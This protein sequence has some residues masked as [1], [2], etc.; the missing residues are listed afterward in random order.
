ME[1]V[2]VHGGRIAEFTE[3]TVSL[4]N[5]PFY[6]KSGLKIRNKRALISEVPVMGEKKVAA[7][8]TERRK[9]EGRNINK[10]ILPE[11]K[12]ID[13]RIRGN[14]RI[15]GIGRAASSLVGI[16]G[17]VESAFSSIDEWMPGERAV[18]VWSGV[19]LG[20]RISGISPKNAV[21]IPQNVSF[22]EA[23]FAVHGARAVKI[24]RSAD[25]KLGNHIAVYGLDLEGNLACQLLSSSG[26][27][28]IALDTDQKKIDLAVGIGAECGFPADGSE[29]SGIMDMTSGR[30]VDTVII[31]DNADLRF[32][33]ETAG[34]ICKDNGKIIVS[35][36]L[37]SGRFAGFNSGRELDIKFLRHHGQ[38]IVKQGMEADQAFR[39]DMEIF[40]GFL[41]ME[42]VRVKPLIAGNIETESDSGTIENSAD[43]GLG[44]ILKY[45]DDEQKS[46]T[47]NWESAGKKIA[48]PLPSQISSGF[49]SGDSSETGI[50]PYVAAVK[51][52]STRLTAGAGDFTGVDEKRKTTNQTKVESIDEIIKNP[53]IKAVFIDGE[54]YRHPELV[55]QSLFSGKHTFVMPPLCFG[56]DELERL[57]KAYEATDAQLMVGYYRRFN[58]VIEHIKETIGSIRQPLSIHYRINAG[59]GENR[60]V[61][62]GPFIGEISHYIDLAAY[63]AGSRPVK[64]HAEGLSAVD[65]SVRSDKNI[66]IMLKFTNGSVAVIN[67]ICGGSEKFSREFL[68]IFGGGKAVQMNDY[69]SLNIADDRGIKLISKKPK[70]NG[71]E[72]MFELWGYY[73]KSGLGSPIPF[74]SLMETSIA[75][76]AVFES[77]ADGRPVWIG[78]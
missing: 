78:L 5:E 40:L 37:E 52:F 11:L 60:S 77:L 46:E 1:E 6:Q 24:V 56:S 14:L 12:S 27:R 44:L 28:V 20:S 30:G 54:D 57:W 49:I 51:T 63:L 75:T 26:G 58:P 32:T 29:I 48:A 10:R 61:S 3:E 38:D 42:K 74:K 41:A 43:N 13:N 16:S 69:N 76:L 53:E 72:K 2:Q 25:I 45:P 70:D 7:L 55:I 31:A 17:I 4:P 18:Y 39:D 62:D 36:D 34:R 71:F 59:S 65:R 47:G 15:D 66:Q 50:F 8:D 64:V 19:N 73:L 23:S 22:E 9:E 67:Y 21:K 68:E 35:G 33:L